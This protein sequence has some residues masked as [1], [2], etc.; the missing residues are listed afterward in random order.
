MLHRS[1]VA[2]IFLA[3]CGGGSG[4]SLS[5]SQRATLAVRGAPIVFTVALADQELDASGMAVASPP[6][7]IDVWM[8]AGDPAE[9]VVFDNGFYVDTQALDGAVTADPL[10]VSPGVFGHGTT[11]AEVEAALG[12]PREVEAETLGGADLEVLRY[13]EPDVVAVSFLDGALVSVVAGLQVSP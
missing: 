12:A 1:A 2:L 3:G 9:R 5:Q 4:G 6:R 10:E 7:R 11:R 13:D 8:Y